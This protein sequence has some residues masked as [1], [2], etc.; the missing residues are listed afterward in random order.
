[1]TAT[2]EPDSDFLPPSQTA[3]EVKFC[4]RAWDVCVQLDRAVSGSCGAGH[5]DVRAGDYACR[6]V[7]A[8]S[9][10]DAAGAFDALSQKACALIENRE[11]LAVET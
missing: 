7:L 8:S 4:H 6:L 3:L 2:P 9:H 1:M 5:A 11:A 10:F